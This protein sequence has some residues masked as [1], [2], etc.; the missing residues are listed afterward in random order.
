MWL[1]LLHVLRLKIYLYPSDR[2]NTCITESAPVSQS[3]TLKSDPGSGH[4]GDDYSGYYSD[5]YTRSSSEAT[6]FKDTESLGDWKD[7]HNR[8]KMRKTSEV[9]ACDES[10]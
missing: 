2:S 6:T 10:P 1:R 7:A 9:A 3:S 5:D 8:D 4:N